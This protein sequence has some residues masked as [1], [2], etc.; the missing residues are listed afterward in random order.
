MSIESAHVLDRAFAF[1]ARADMGGTCVGRS[2]FGTLVT[3]PELPLRQDSNYLLIDRTDASADELATEL[4]RCSLRVVYVREPVTADRLAPAFAD[5]GWKTHK[6]VVMQHLRQPAKQ[7]DTSIVSDVDEE[8]LRPVRRNQI[9]NAP[10]GS[11]ELADQLLAAKRMIA[12]RVETHFLAVMA[13]DEVAA[14]ADVYLA[15]GTAQIEDVATIEEYRNH[16]Y[17]TALVLH[18]LELARDAEADLVFLVADAD[19]W[20]RQLYARLGFNVI[21]GYQKFSP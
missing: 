15:G 4:E 1:M 14:Y 7:G 21:G 11:P 6:G 16:G 20:P 3:T 19:D 13:G 10:W 17:A 18:G 8:T 12:G 5:L 9:V 2:P